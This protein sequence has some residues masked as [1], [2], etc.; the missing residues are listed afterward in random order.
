M[1]RVG[2]IGHFGFGKDLANGQTIK[3]KNIVNALS[4]KIGND[5]ILKYDTH[6]G[7]RA[8]FQLPFQI[9]SCLKNVEN[10]VIMPANRGIQLITPLLLLFNKKRKRKIHYIVIGGWLPS[11]CLKKPKLAAQI[12]KFDYIYVETSTMKKSLMQQGFSNI[13]VMPNFK[14]ITPLNSSQLIY[15]KSEPFKICTFSRVMKEKGIGDIVEIVKRI[16]NCQKR[17][18]YIL[19]IYGQIDSSQV[20]WFD[21]LRS[22]FP[23]YIRYKGCVSS[24]ESVE[25]IKEYFALVFPTRFYTEGVPGTILDAFAAGVPVIASKWESYSDLIED[26][27]TGIG[28]EFGNMDELLT[29]LENFANCPESLNKLKVDCLGKALLY[30]SNSIIETLISRLSV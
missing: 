23:N 9:S 3:T 15:Q 19:D 13:V 14:D 22:N 25:T 18:V 1:V 5:N 6:G 24:N 7:L 30:S 27:I 28:Y 8:L 11:L 16:N 29:I 20:D 12:K 26:S 10:V 21:A 4:K 2:I 17:I